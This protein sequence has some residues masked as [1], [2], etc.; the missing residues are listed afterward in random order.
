MFD[1][2]L[3]E[4]AV[5]AIIDIGFGARD[6]VLL[7]QDLRCAGWRYRVR[8]VEHGGDPAEGRGR[9]TALPVLL[10]WIAGIAK[11]HVH[12]DGARQKMQTAGIERL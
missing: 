3:A 2:V 6:R 10:M 9:G 4:Q 8:H 1:G 12:V 7:R 11:M 5:E